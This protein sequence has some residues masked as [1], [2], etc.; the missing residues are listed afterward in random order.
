MSKHRINALNQDREAMLKA[1]AAARVEEAQREQH[2]KDL[3]GIVSP[4]TITA[5]LALPNLTSTLAVASHWA[6]LW[7]ERMTKLAEDR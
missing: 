7:P 6:L 3:K 4:E 1:V 5:I 2:V